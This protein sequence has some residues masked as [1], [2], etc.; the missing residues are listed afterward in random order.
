MNNK[1][2]TNHTSFFSNDEIKPTALNGKTSDDI[3]DDINKTF[4]TID[5][6]GVTRILYST[7]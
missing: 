3:I 1:A 5:I 6:L 7:Y 4:S 2:H